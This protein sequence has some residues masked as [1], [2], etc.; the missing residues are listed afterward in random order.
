MSFLYS[1]CLRLYYS[2]IRCASLFNTRAK[3]FFQSRAKEAP[4]FS[5]IDPSKSNLLIHCAS[6][7]EY[8]TAKPLIE[9]YKEKFNIH[10]TFYSA[11]GFSIAKKESTWSSLQ[12]LPL[13]YDQISLDKFLGRLSPDLVIIV[14][15]EYWYNFLKALNSRQ[16][17]FLFYNIS[18]ASSSW[19]FHPINRFV[20]DQVKRAKAFFVR[21]STTSALLSKYLQEDS[22]SE[23]GDTR[24]LRAD[25]IQF[26][27]R[28]RILSSPEIKTIV[29]GSVWKEDVDI[30]HSSILK[31]CNDKHVLLAPHE[32]DINTINDLC[33]N[34]P[35][36]KLRSNC[37]LDFSVPGITILDTIGELK[38]CYR[39]AS[40][41]Y[42]G[43]GLGNGQ[44]NYIEACIHQIPVFV[45][46]HQ[47]RDPLLIE[48]LQKGYVI[49][50]E[51]EEE[52]EQ[53]LTLDRRNSIINDDYGTYLAAQVSRAKL[54]L[55]KLDEL[56]QKHV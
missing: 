54:G 23:T 43:G 31:H 56:I 55:Q 49:G 6:H 16:I 39:E 7:G 32:V 11:N 8:E 28:L 35:S 53:H 12:Y 22:I 9:R 34:F 51:T 26:D 48:L 17:P 46:S 52:I 30:W 14:Q 47:T 5:R 15:Y 42:V 27:K 20:F 45:G 19:L 36:A 40:Y 13:D 3:F 41:A 33:S 4:I 50:V 38:H 37:G 1:V 44:H 24:W 10:L 21:N 25:Q 2:F 18:I 29:L